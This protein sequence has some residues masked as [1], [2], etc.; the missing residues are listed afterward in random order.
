[1]ENKK[2]NVNSLDTDISSRAKILKPFLHFPMIPTSLNNSS[3]LEKMK[4][5]RISIRI[6]F[7]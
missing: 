5:Y 3:L 1:M 2:A 6:H 4:K 7:A